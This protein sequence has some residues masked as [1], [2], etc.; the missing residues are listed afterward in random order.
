MRWMFAALLVAA[1]FACQKPEDQKT[2]SI[3]T[4]AGKDARAQMSPAARIQLDSG[5]AAFKAKDFD[6][7]RA[8][9]QRVTEIDKDAP[10]GWFGI[11]MT[12][13]ARGNAAAADSALKRV[14]SEVP[15]ATL[16]H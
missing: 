11:Y 5:N 3:E 13:Q 8:H 7:A 12:E 1:S 10:V 2:E 14:R 6:K 15:G 16:V 4:G 9:Y